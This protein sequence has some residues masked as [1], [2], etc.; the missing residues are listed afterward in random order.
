MAE[1]MTYICPTC[2]AEA[3]VGKP[4]P[5]CAPVKKRKPEAAK[6]KRPWEQDS[7]A[8]GLDLPDDDFDYEDFIAREFGGKPHKKTGLAWYWWLLAAVMLV[9]M[10]AWA[11]RL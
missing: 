1:V 6:K 2:G 11:L 3:R 5:G 10:A 4:C 8:D 7:A 9:I